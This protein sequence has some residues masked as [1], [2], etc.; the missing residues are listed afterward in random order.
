MY[1]G[2]RFKVS[3]AGLVKIRSKEKHS[4]EKK[5][6]IQTEIGVIKKDLPRPLTIPEE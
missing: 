1:T 5:S 2:P 3:S 4:I 6:K